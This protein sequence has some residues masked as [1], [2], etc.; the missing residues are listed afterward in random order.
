MLYLRHPQ[1]PGNH[2]SLLHL[3][4][5]AIL[6]VLCKWNHTVCSLLGL[7]FVRSIIPLSFIQSIVCIK[8][9]F[10]SLLLARIPWY[11]YSTVCLTIHL[12]KDIWFVSS[13]GDIINKT[14]M[15]IHVQ[16]FV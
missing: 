11:G 7:A 8:S 10:F 15:S 3:Y 12:L 2:G 13:L 16:V 9:L 4:S 5:L 1:A 14:S 6:R